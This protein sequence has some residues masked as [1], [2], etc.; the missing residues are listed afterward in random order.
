M[1]RKLPKELRGLS[2]LGYT[3]L[4][5]KAGI[6]PLYMWEMSTGAHLNFTAV[7]AASV[8]YVAIFPSLLAYLFWNRA[9]SQVGPNRAGQFIHLMPVFGTLLSVVFLDERLFFYHL[10]G[11]AIV[12]VGIYLATV[13]QMG[14]G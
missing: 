3:I 1:L 7:T 6:A 14:S 11:I 12:G 10:I 13:K 5:G 4:L 9:V 8:A 2:L